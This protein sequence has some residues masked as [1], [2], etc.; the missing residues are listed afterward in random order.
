MNDFPEAGPPANN[1]PDAEIMNDLPLPYI[2]L[3]AHGIVTRANRA[4]LALHPP[5]RGELIG[6]MA[7]DLMAADEKDPSC[8]AYFS[9]I[10]SGEN[11]PVVRRSLFDRSGQFRT[12][13]M[14]RSLIR[15]AQGNPTGMRMICVDVTEA[16]QAL[17][18][19]SLNRFWLES[20]VDSM[21]EA[22]IV[23]DAVGFIRLVNPAAA[24]LLGRK[25][26]E[27]T[28]MLIEQGVPILSSGPGSD[29]A[30]NFNRSLEEPAKGVATVLDYERRELCVEFRTAPIFNKENGSTTGV[31]AVLRRLEPCG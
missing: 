1:P 14:H 20:I 17:E 10:E 23:T 27:L 4:T 19:T 15:D 31:V 6:R 18:D 13:E 22:V 5:D 9:T 28:G 25:A 30:L 16:K 7:W 12:Y 26:A 2:E 29:S 24:A 11:P 3:D 21:P 8:A